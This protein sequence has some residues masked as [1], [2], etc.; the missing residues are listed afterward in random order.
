VISG[1]CPGVVASLNEGGD[2]ILTFFRFPREQWKL[3]SG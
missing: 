3:A 2:E 1:R